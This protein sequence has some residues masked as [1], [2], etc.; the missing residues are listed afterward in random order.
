MSSNKEKIIFEDNFDSGL[1]QGWEWLRQNKE[2]WRIQDSG[3]EIRVVP[4]D[5][6]TVKNALIRS[7]PNRNN[8]TFAIEVSVSKTIPPAIAIFT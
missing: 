2:C 8:G 3:L 5:E 4:G 6:N 7:A 1:K